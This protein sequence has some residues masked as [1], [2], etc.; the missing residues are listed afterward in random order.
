[1]GWWLSPVDEE[2]GL[3]GHCWRI[4]G[5]ELISAGAV[6]LVMFFDASSS[7]GW[8]SLCLWL[9]A[10]L[11]HSVCTLAWMPGVHVL[12]FIGSEATHDLPRVV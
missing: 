9:Q 4:V 10:G 8:W 12:F 7:F 3:S 1:V 11:Y 5:M 2:K 6:V